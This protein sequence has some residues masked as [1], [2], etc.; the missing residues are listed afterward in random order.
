[1]NLPAGVTPRD[2]DNLCRPDDS[3]PNRHDCVGCKREIE[4]C[5]DTG[6]FFISE[7]F[8]TWKPTHRS[9][10]TLAFK[11]EE[12]WWCNAGC[13]NDHAVDAEPAIAAR[14]VLHLVKGR[15]A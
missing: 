12:G 9:D 8:P 2:I 10:F 11:T 6:W 3:F 4:Q 7:D 1:M 14:P 15:M 13:Y 5:P